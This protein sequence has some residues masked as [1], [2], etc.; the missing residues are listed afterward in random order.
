MKYI[1][2]LFFLLLASHYSFGQT[3]PVDQ[4]SEKVKIEKEIEEKKING[5]RIP[6]LSSIPNHNE[7]LYIVNGKPVQHS[8][9]S[10]I[11]HNDIERI[12]VIK[13]ANATAIYGASGANGVIV[14]TLKETRKKKSKRKLKKEKKRK[15]K[16]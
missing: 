12:D 8:E 15:P 9:L 5:V 6:S 4:N 3:E 2:S 14:I 11:S 7:P 10:E 1:V 16:K 13:D